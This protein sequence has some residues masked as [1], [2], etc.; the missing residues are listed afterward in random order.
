MKK[1]PF[2]NTKVNR[3]LDVKQVAF[4]AKVVVDALTLPELPDRTTAWSVLEALRMA[5]ATVLDMEREDVQAQV[6]GRRGSDEVTA[7][8]FDPMPG[9]SGLLEQACERWREIVT[10]AQRIVRDCPACCDTSCVDCLQDFR[11]SF[12]H[13]HLDRHRALGFFEEHGVELVPMHPIAAALPE[14][15]EG[16]PTNGAE[17]RLRELLERAHLKGGKWQQQIVLGAP[18]PS[19]TPDVLFESEDAG[20]KPLVVYL[21]GLSRDLHG[22]AATA[23]RDMMIRSTL[24]E[25]GYEVVEIPASHLA[26]RDDMKRHMAESRL[27]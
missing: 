27:R 26:S 23:Q 1:D 14:D 12:Q 8:L 2:A 17:R 6:I 19:T 5:M 13:K 24:R 22:N 16:E 21:D 10:Q 25:R 7:M 11:N 15:G 9:G 18:H 4:F 3:G 20:E